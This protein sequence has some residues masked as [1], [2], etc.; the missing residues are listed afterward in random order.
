MQLG[1]A[2]YL[3]FEHDGFTVYIRDDMKFEGDLA[4]IDRMD[5]RGNTF[6]IVRNVIE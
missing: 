6:L 2:K 5:Y 4:R 3:K 1:K